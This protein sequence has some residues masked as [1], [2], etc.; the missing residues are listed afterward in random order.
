MRQFDGWFKI[1][2][3]APERGCLV[4]RGCGPT[5]TVLYATLE[6]AAQAFVDVYPQ[7]P[8]I[9]WEGSKYEPDYTHR[10]SVP[11]HT[12]ENGTWWNSEYGREVFLF[13]KDD[14]RDGW[15]DPSRDK[16]G[17][18]YRGAF[19][20]DSSLHTVP[21]YGYM[22]CKTHIGAFRSNGRPGDGLLPIGTARGDREYRNPDPV[23]IGGAIVDQVE[24]NRIHKL[25]GQLPTHI[26]V[27]D[28]SGSCLYLKEI[29]WGDEPQIIAREVAG[30]LG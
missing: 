2:E 23:N 1:P 18:F 4:F 14:R 6:E 30:L 8:G 12:R 15:C 19:L 9:V 21:G 29:V 10:C 17:K 24:L 16:D 22:E 5:V 20:K 13:Y 7:Y 25:T 26:T 11:H 3:S 27:W 28:P